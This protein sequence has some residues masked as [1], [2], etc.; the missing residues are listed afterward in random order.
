MT[1]LLRRLWFAVV[2]LIASPCVA[3]AAP[4]ARALVLDAVAGPG[5]P[6]AAALQLAL[7]HEIG[8][9]V[10]TTATSAADPVLHVRRAGPGQADVRLTTAD[11]SAAGRKVRLPS[12][13]A[14]AAE[15]IALLA[16]N[17]LRDD[18]TDLLNTL[19]R[20]AEPV[21]QAP[22]PPEPLP[23]A[24]PVVLTPPPAMPLPVAAAP[25]VVAP[26]SVAP[27]VQLPP[28]RR[29]HLELWSQTAGPS[30]LGLNYGGRWLHHLLAAGAQ[31]TDRRAVPVVAYGVGLEL[32][33]TQRTTIGLDAIY[34]L[35]IGD[36]VTGQKNL[37]HIGQL[38]VL[39]RVE[40]ASKLALFAG[41]TY[42][43]GVAR[44]PDQSFGF[45]ADVAEPDTGKMHHF[46]MQTDG[47]QVYQWAGVT[48]GLSGF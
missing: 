36:F 32:H 14:R 31:T 44:D 40:L 18:S 7:E 17:L 20:A 48:L 1:Q 5:L 37:S 38:R 30:L 35:A 15:T 34:H 24:L 22:P 46:A 33:P 43:L 13:P 6:D 21:V 25:V 28:N 8:I 11:A 27:S 10:R 39:A 26:A 29:T 47:L 2:C 3:I 12:D 16:E 23:K 19:R 45:T 4:T 9:A 41:P 42:N